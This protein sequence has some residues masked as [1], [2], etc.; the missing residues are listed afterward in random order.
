MVIAI[1][2]HTWLLRAD[3]HVKDLVSLQMAGF[4]VADKLQ[5]ATKQV[6]TDAWRQTGETH[7]S[8][9]IE[10]WCLLQR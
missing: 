1:E 10:C 3:V 7:K 5:Y 8:F 4:Q 6:G 2:W 9:S